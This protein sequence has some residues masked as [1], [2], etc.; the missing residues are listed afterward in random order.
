MYYDNCSVGKMPSFDLLSYGQY[1]EEQKKSND[2]L[3]KS[4]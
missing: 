3:I 2:N 1:L 4:I